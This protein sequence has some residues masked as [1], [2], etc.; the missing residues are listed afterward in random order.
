MRNIRWLDFQDA[1]DDRGRLTAIEG[2]NHI[3]FQIARVFYVHQV[4]EKTDRGGHAH[5]DTDQVLT[6]I[7]GS[8]KVDTSDGSGVSTFVLDNPAKGIYVPRMVY[9]RLYDFSLGAVLLVSVT[10]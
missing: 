1:I 10:K 8:M 6:C 3:P 7:C 9:V 5:R 2:D 4:S